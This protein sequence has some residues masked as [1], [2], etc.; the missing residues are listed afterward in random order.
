MFAGYQIVPQQLPTIAIAAG[1]KS[2]IKLRDLTAK[3]DDRVCHLLGFIIEEQLTAT[4]TTTPTT[5][6]LNKLISNLEFFDGS[7]VRFKGTGNDL[8]QFERLE[9]GGYG[10]GEGRI[11]A[12]TSAQPKFT[13]RFLSVGPMRMYGAPK[14]WVLPNVLLD[15]GELRIT[16]GALTDISADTTVITGNIVVTALSVLLDDLRIPPFYERQTFTV[17]SDDRITGK[18]LYAFLGYSKDTN[19]S[20]FSAGDIG[21]VF[22]DTGTAQVIPTVDS[23]ILTSLYNREFNVG[24]LNGL[25]GDPRNGTHDVNQRI[26][27]WS[28]GTALAAMTADLQAILAMPP[29]GRITK[30]SSR[31][32]NSLRVKSSGAVTS[33]LQ[34]HVGRILPQDGG[35]VGTM[36]DRA[37][38]KLGMKG[39]LRFD[40]ASGKTNPGGKSRA[41]Q[42][43]PFAVK[44]S[45]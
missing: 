28:G 17:N 5:V 38:A 8:R 11:A 13:R 36:V 23:Q 18:G 37:L 32:D 31:V 39:A 16:Q 40:L 22:V 35:V 14:D 45:R 24:L 25:Q 4:Y 15:N 33:G 19:Y 9:N 43:L 7:Q 27:D 10:D 44:L 26:V 41:R 1:S 3:V 42:Y 29:G 34:L 30:I 21:N 2:V 12:A 6:G 20:A